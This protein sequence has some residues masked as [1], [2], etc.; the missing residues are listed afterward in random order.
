MR[1][2]D[3]SSDVCSSDLIRYRVVP[4]TSPRAQLK[5]FLA[6]HAGESGIVYCLSRARVD[7]VAEWLVGQG[8]TALPY[9][10]GLDKDLRARHQ[11]RFLREDG[12][13]MVATIDRKSTRL[14]SSH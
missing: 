13:V 10:A 2:S 9:H 8:H 3:W 11:D 14:N 5:T 7:Q 6:E 1:I 4:K 12:V